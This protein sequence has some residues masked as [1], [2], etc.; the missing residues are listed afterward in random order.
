MNVLEISAAACGVA[1][2]ILAALQKPYC[3]WFGIA[4]AVF[5]ILFDW[6]LKFYQDAILQMYY[7]L[8]G[9]YGW[10]IWIKKDKRNHTIH[11]KHI[12]VRELYWALL[13]LVTL[14]FIAGF[15]FEKAGNALPYLD[16]FTA[17]GSFIATYFTIKKGLESWLMWITLDV[18][19]CIQYVLKEAYIT[20]IFY[21]FLAVMAVYGYNRWK[22]EYKRNFQA[23]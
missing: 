4:S 6:Q 9:F 3:W 19:L 14:T 22:R 2:V 11:V 12:S 17:I 13:L 7:V 21:L 23:A 16:A 5:Y 8:A 1:Y 18:V 10:Y 20:G 15:V